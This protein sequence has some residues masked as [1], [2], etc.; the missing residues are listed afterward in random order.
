M[1]QRRRPSKEDR[2]IF[3]DLVR[4][5]REELK[6]TQEEIAEE[7]GCSMHWINDIEQGKVA[8]TWADAFR[9]SILLGV[10]LEDFA[11]ETGVKPLKPKSEKKK[12]AFKA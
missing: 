10:R 9:L 8:P 11:K 5:R 6:Y 12:A 3:G 1:I 4:H 7:L 2:R